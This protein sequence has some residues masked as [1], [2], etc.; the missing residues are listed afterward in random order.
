M[1]LKIIILS[2]TLL[3]FPVDAQEAESE[4]QKELNEGL[5]HFSEGS[6]LLLQSLIGELLPLYEEL[7][8]LI[9]ELN[10]YHPPEMLPN[11]DIIIRRKTPLEREMEKNESDE[12]EL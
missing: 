2:L 1:Y 7:G 4:L 8:G 9:D 11:G 6:R 10:A 5:E 3:T 12:I